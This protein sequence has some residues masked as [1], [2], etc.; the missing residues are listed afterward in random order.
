MLTPLLTHRQALSDVPPE[1]V[2]YF[3]AHKQIANPRH[4]AAPAVHWFEYKRCAGAF[5]DFDVAADAPGRPQSVLMF[6]MQY[7]SRESAARKAKLNVNKEVSFHADRDALFNAVR[8]ERAAAY[9][10]EVAAALQML[11]PA[12]SGD[13]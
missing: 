5:V 3:W 10:P 2:P 4:V 11:F 1:L 8:D 13:G 6:H 9:A 7:R 12:R